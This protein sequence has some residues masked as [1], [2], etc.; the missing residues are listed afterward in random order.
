MRR[1]TLIWR[2]GSPDEVANG[3]HSLLEALGSL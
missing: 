2:V 1:V 3:L